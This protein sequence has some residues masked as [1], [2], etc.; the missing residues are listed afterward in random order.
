MVHH[1]SLNLEIEFTKDMNVEDFIAMTT[2]AMVACVY[3]PF[4]IAAEDKL[5]TMESEWKRLQLKAGEVNGYFETSREAKWQQKF[6]TI[7][8]KSDQVRKDIVA[9]LDVV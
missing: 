4:H 1:E 9:L 5:Q 3:M 8:R 6:Q 2:R 7:C